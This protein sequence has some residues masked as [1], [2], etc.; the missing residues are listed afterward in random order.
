MPNLVET[1]G[2][3]SFQRSF[4]W[5]W[6]MLGWSALAGLCLA[7]CPA[8]NSKPKPISRRAVS[9][10]SS[11]SQSASPVHRKVRIISMTPAPNPRTRIPV[12]PTPL[13]RTR[14][15]PRKRP[16]VARLGTT[17]LSRRR[18]QPRKRPTVTRL[19]TTPTPRGGALF[20][21]AP[22]PRRQALPK[23]DPKTVFYPLEYLL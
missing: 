13:P 8:Q 15:Q 23:I 4:R 22:A 18:V 21:K 3:F 5:P 11:P 17:P 2:V 9:K 14:V 7:G 1:L 10:H 19:G 6:M 16:T 12:T 20:T